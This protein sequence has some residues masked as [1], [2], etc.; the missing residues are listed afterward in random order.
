MIFKMPFP[1]NSDFANVSS[2]F[3][4]TFSKHNLHKFSWFLQ[5]ERERKREALEKFTGLAI[6]GISCVTRCSSVYVRFMGGHLSAGKE[7]LRRARL[8]H[9]LTVSAAGEAAP[10]LASIEPAIDPPRF[11]VGTRG[12][13]DSCTR[14]RNRL[15][16]LGKAIRFKL[17]A[18]PAGLA[19][20]FTAIWADEALRSVATAT[21]RRSC[22]AADAI[23]NYGDTISVILTPPSPFAKNESH[24]MLS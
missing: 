12:R 3:F 10:F 23:D 4:Q 7:S 6:Y 14:S 18:G 22:T 11:N 20:H 5:R 9:K 1:Q 17:P 2:F 21:F 19:I 13:A 16:P 8:L 24:P 15:V